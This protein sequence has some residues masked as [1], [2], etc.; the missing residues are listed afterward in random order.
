MNTLLE[1]YSIK[2]QRSFLAR[3]AGR[4]D[5]EDDLLADLDQL[6]LQMNSDE[7]MQSKELA[8]A[9]KALHDMQTS[10]GMINLVSHR[11][12]K[13]SELDSR[14]TRSAPASARILSGGGP[15]RDSRGTSTKRSPGL[16]ALVYA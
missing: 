3:D 8:H 12:I 15:V 7:R 4:I 5:E 11:S 1:M 14:Q 13:N 9:A 10:G 2:L 16:S 6:W